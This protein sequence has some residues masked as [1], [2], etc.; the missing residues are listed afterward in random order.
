MEWLGLLSGLLP[1]GGWGAFLLLVSVLAWM[2]LT[3][4][5]VSRRRLRDAQADAASWRETVEIERDR[6][7]ELQGQITTLT[8]QLGRAL[9][10]AR[11]EDT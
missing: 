8:R 11:R 5:L 1:A 10:A 2:L 9:A 6:N 7:D 4:R 3:D